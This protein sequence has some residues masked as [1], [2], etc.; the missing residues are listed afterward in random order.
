MKIKII[1]LSFSFF[2]L[3]NIGFAQKGGQKSI[4]TQVSIKKYHEI[5]ELERM[6]KGQL[7][8]LYIE[9]IESLAKML[10]Y[11]AYS[12]KPGITMDDIGIPNTKD[13]NKALEEEHEA[14]RLFILETKKF[15]QT[16]LPYTDTSNLINAILFYEEIFKS[17]HQYGDY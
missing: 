16:L 2:M 7:I 1:L 15:Q 8:T 13:N 11:I 14:V 17:I 6:K 5:D 10:P 3:A 9:R 4:I 12:T